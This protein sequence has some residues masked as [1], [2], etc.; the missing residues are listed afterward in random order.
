MLNFSIIIP[1]YNVEAYVEHCIESIFAQDSAEAEI[2]CLIIDDCSP[3]G[4]M[5]IVRRMVEAYKGPITFR[6]LTH[7]RNRGLSAAR[8]TG[9]EN[10]TG[11]YILFIDSDDYLTPGSIQYF[12]NNLRKYPDVDML[13]ANIKNCKADNLLI[14]NI[15]EP[16]HIDNPDV[17]YSRMLH[18]QIY[19]QAVNKLMRRSMILEGGLR[20]IEGILYE[21]QAWSY[22][23]FQH[24]SSI[25]LLPQVTYIYEY[26]QQSIV[27]TSF[28]QEKADRV[29]RSYSVSVATMLDNPPGGKRY[30]RNMTADYVLYMSNPLMNGVDVLMHCPISPD[31]AK[32]FRQIRKRVFFYSL[33]CGRLLLTIFLLLLFSPFYN[34]Q[35]MGIFRRHYY[36]IESTVNWLSHLTDFLHRNK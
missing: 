5:A 19:A 35:K 8:N 24:L 28:T 15:Q 14:Q 27:N 11:D 9:I 4:S 13:M 2:E 12:V 18:H 20:F 1:I 17:F 22:L 21:D 31:T 26:N 32:Q 3:D 36:E 10:A 23:L 16:W 34:I 7:E 6:M 29:L 25:V 30:R 33:R